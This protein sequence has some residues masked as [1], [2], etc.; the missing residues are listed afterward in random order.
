MTLSALAA[1]AVK[2]VLQT[3]ASPA[4]GGSENMN[5]MSVKR[6][7][8]TGGFSGS[9]GPFSACAGGRMGEWDSPGPCQ[10]DRTEHTL[11]HS[12]LPGPPS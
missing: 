4:V 2:G 3:L 6:G 12:L 11:E 9:P 1:S 10:Q 7:A 5:L 8:V